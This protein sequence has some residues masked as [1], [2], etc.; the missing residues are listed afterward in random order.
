MFGKKENDRE[1]LPKDLL[2][3]LESSPSRLEEMIQAIAEGD[4]V[5]NNLMFTPAPPVA[6]SAQVIQSDWGMIMQQANFGSIGGLSGYN[7]AF[8]RSLAGI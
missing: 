2:E 8:R 4:V 5:G 7:D 6:A 3:D 1:L